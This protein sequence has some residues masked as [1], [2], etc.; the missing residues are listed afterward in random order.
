MRKLLLFIIMFS[1]GIHV[2][3]AIGLI[4][5]QAVSKSRGEIGNTASFKYTPVNDAFREFK[6]KVGKTVQY[7][8]DWYSDEWIPTDTILRTWSESGKLLT[9]KRRDHNIHYKYDALDR[10]ISR[11]DKSSEYGCEVYDYKYDD[12][13]EDMVISYTN[14]SKYNNGDSLLIESVHQ[15]IKRDEDGNVVET[16]II[17]YT[18]AYDDISEITTYISYTDGKASCI[19]DSAEYNHSVMDNIIWERTDGQIISDILGLRDMELITEENRLKT[20][21]VDSVSLITIEYPDD[22]GSYVY[23]YA[24]KYNVSDDEKLIRIFTVLDDNK[25]Y[26]KSEIMNFE[27]ITDNGNGD[28]YRDSISIE[29][30]EECHYDDFGLI[31][32]Y[33]DKYIQNGAEYSENY[34][35]TVEYDSTTG[36]PIKYILYSVDSD[37]SINYYHREDYFDVSGNNASVRDIEI[38]DED[39]AI[40]YYTIDGMAIDAHNLSKGIYIRRQG[41]KTEK[42]FIK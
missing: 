16:K 27:L 14:Y 13:V 24:Y 32:S 18:A 3:L 23:N 39:A 26:Y 31:I 19:V 20:A 29:D 41:L 9:E 10:C 5:R 35:S 25:S 30:E 37:G 42:V 22:R 11:I 8:Y 7:H 34:N 12:I 2:L 28:I 15:D 17:S 21:I 33:K 36:Y 1:L 4:P 40:Q 6:F 38:T